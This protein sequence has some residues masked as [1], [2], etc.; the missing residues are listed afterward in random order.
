M[1]CNGPFLYISLRKPHMKKIAIFYCL[2]LLSPILSAQQTV[3]LVGALPQQVNETSGLIFY[4][5]KLITH[6]DSGNATELYELD[7][8]SL[9]V[10][11][12]I[13][14]NGA[15]NRDWEDITQDENYIYIGDIGN[16]NGNR[17]D[18]TI[19]RISKSEFDGLDTVVADRIEFSYEDQQSF[20]ATPNSD[21]DAEAIT[22][23]KGQLTLFTKRWQSGGSAAYTIP[24]TPGEHTAVKLG[25]VQASGLVTAATYNPES[26]ILYLLGYS[27]L[28]QPFLLRF[29][30]PPGSL[31]F[32]GTSQSSNLDIGFAQTEG[33]CFV[34]H[35]TYYISSE[36]FVNSNP[37]IALAASLF[38]L[39]T[40]DAPI[41]NTPPPGEDPGDDPNPPPDED[42]EPNPLPEDDN[43]DELII[44]RDF[45]SS[46]LQY[47]LNTEDDLFGRAIYDL[48]GRRIQYTPKSEIVSNS[49][50]IS[51]LGKSI[52]YL[53][54]YLRTKILS[55]PFISD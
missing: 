54:F 21:W 2:L 44:Y 1:E 6:N 53:T 22:L 46:S 45:G 19:Y 35:N 40:P 27:Q 41:E 26:N 13:T 9:Q 49:I 51:A 7:P 48:N 25:T 52:Y 29:E 30:D 20:L 50:D 28:L 5:G 4:N 24:N 16:I 15:V 23:I 43:P 36:K 18:L 42:P 55:K 11:R 3:S 10:T 34:D 38:R 33:I 8:A 12:V 17:T 47:I 39:E 37:P 14:I 32:G 31:S